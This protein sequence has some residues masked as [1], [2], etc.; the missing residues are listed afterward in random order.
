MLLASQ[1]KPHL[2]PHPEPRPKPP[3]RSRVDW[4]SY[5][6]V[7]DLMTELNPAYRALVEDYR[8]FLGGLRLR[9][10]DHLVDVGAGTGNFSLVAADEWPH[11][12]VTHVDASD[13]MNARARDKR[14]AL[15]VG[16]LEIRTADVD[17]FDLPAGSVALATVVH[18]L[19]AFPDPEAFIER[20]YRWLR[21]GGA[22]YVC[23]PSG[24]LNVAEWSRYIFRSA[25]R[26]RGWWRA[27]WLFWRA[28]GAIGLNRRIARA[29]D[30]GAFW[31]HDA[32]SF[33]AAF[34]AAGFQV[35]AVRSAY[36]GVSDLVIAQKPMTISRVANAG[37]AYAAAV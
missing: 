9:A 16:N 2:H 27:A 25:C 8:Q 5:A 6:A 11:C 3:A 30:G 7:Y 29:V 10:G 24:Q 32:V 19:Y 17:A 20:L 23:D 21:P 33:R 18:A 37:E 35:H 36:R 12:R 28:R 13:A 15:G 26:E 4:R 31:R 1:P 34:E 14:S 22:V